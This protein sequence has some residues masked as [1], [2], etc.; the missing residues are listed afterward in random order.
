MQSITQIEKDKLEWRERIFS[1]PLLRLLI[2]FTVP[3]FISIAAVF[4]F[5]VV[6]TYFASK[7]GT[8]A[9]AAMGASFPVLF[10]IT[11]IGL[12]LGVGTLSY[13][14]PK[15]GRSEFNQAALATGHGII[16]ILIVSA[17]IA[18]I[19]F[20]ASDIYLQSLGVEAGVF[21]LA[22]TYNNIVIYGAFLYILPIVLAAMIRAS[23]N[24]NMPA[25]IMGIGCL[26]N[27]ILDPILMFGLGPAPRLELAGAAY[28]TVASAAVAGIIGLIY[29]IRERMIRFDWTGLTNSLKHISYVGGLS[30][31]S[32]LLLPFAFSLITMKLAGFGTGVIGGAGLGMKLEPLLLALP[33]AMTASVPPIVGIT[34]GANNIVRTRQTIKLA[35]KIVFVWQLIVAAIIWILAGSIVS[36][37]TQEASVAESAIL[38]LRLISLTYGFEGMLFVI[39]SSLNAIGKPIPSFLINSIRLLILVSLLYIFSTGFSMLWVYGTIMASNITAGILALWI[40]KYIIK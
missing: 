39:S 7:L 33:I 25:I 27:I 14:A 8:T 26:L 32:N 21:D 4:L 12:G 3:S 9:L 35:N 2:S 13:I 22:K 10:M 18:V 40:Q 31:F 30:T 6:D 20:F 19:G 16:F 28:A 36:L 17:I 5:G 34:W 11:T 1:A 15:I 24:A 29:M 23:G 38:Y 37:F